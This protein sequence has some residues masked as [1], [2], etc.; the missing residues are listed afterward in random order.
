[1]DISNAQEY[2]G[3]ALTIIGVLSVVAT[4]TPT[5][6]DNM[7]LVG[8]RKALNLLAMNWGQA[9]NLVIPGDPD[10]KTERDQRQARKHKKPRGK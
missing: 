6:I 4:F 1:M 5:P 3:H 10:S 8:L 9:E 7:V 2:I